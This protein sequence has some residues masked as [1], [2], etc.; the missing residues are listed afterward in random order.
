MKPQ[1]IFFAIL[2]FIMLVSTNADTPIRQHN[3]FEL[4]EYEEYWL[5]K[6][7]CSHMSKKCTYDFVSIPNDWEERG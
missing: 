6:L 5:I 7:I 4:E 1:I 2:F 3:L